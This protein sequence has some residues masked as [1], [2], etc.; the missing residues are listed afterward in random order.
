MEPVDTNDPVIKLCIAGTQ[1]EFQGR[2]D[3]ARALYLQAWKAASDDY[4][5]CIA[6]HYMARYQENPKEAL[7][8]N[9][10]ALR[11]ADSVMDDR[12]KSFYSSLYLNMGQSHELLGEQSQAHKYYELAAALGVAH[13][14][15]EQSEK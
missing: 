3:E 1:A 5:A 2:V 6:A 15:Q 11:R 8:W 10:E 14:L 12:A 9:Q 13:Q 7:A 4:Q